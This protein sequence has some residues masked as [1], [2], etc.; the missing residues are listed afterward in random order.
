MPDG[1]SR[2]HFPT[3][4]RRTGEVPRCTIS[5]PVN[6]DPDGNLVKRPCA[7]KKLDWQLV[8]M[9][10]WRALVETAHVLADRVYDQYKHENGSPE[11][12]RTIAQCRAH[13]EN[14]EEFAFKGRMLH[15]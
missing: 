12:L 15:K 9:A 2:E 10:H 5:V 6:I 4:T 7:A 3:N 11:H 1:Q 13:L 8:C 14:I